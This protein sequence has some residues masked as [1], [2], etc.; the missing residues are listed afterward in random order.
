[1]T[2]I[3]YYFIL[4]ACIVVS[5]KVYESKN[6]NN[7]MLNYIQ[8]IDSSNT[9]K[10]LDALSKGFETIAE[11]EENDWLPYYYAGYVDVRKSMLEKDKTY[12]D[13]YLNQA[14]KFI[15][16]AD[17]LEPGNSEII[18]L[19]ALSTAIRISIDPEKRLSKYDEKF[20]Q[21]IE[22]ALIKNPKNPR[23]ELLKGQMIYYYHSQEL[24]SAKTLLEAS[25]KKYNEFELEDDLYPNWGKDQLELLLMKI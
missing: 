25:L 23:P 3:V 6:Y 14:D 10:Q 12:K 15:S 5:E 8:L 13:T 22:L 19:K 21:N 4:T 16:I 20:N 7:T 24:Y 17:S 9:I 2:F 11:K 1:M 18:T